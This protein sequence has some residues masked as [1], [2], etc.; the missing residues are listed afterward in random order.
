MRKGKM[1]AQGAHAAMAFIS[2]RLIGDGLMLEDVEWEWLQNSFAK[3]CVGVG[4][5]AELQDI[6]ED[7]IDFGVTVQPI[8]DNGTTE[9]GGVPTLTCCAVGPDYVGRVD[10]ITGGLKLL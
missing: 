2:R 7:A 4:S 1:V 8:M 9:F 6:I 3:V 10:A 5:E